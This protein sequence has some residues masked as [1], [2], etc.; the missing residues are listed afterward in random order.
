MKI[1]EVLR[2]K[3]LQIKLNPELVPQLRQIVDAGLVWPGDLISKEATKMLCNL[4]LVSRMDGWYVATAE[5][6]YWLRIS[7]Q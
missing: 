4:G 3:T 6:E 5:G 2:K 1:P 7:Q